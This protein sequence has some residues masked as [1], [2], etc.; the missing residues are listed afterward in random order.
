[1]NV[2]D[3]VGLGISVVLVVVVVEVEVVGVVV[4]DWSEI[5]VPSRTEIV[6]EDNE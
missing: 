1:M 5:V 6:F 2:V 4:V 3:S